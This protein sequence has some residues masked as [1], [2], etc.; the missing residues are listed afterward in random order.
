MNRLDLIR[1]QLASCD[2]IDKT[3]TISTP[4]NFKPV[5][6]EEVRQALATDSVFREFFESQMTEFQK[7]ACERWIS[8]L[9]DTINKTT[10]DMPRSMKG[11]ELVFR[12][13]K[14]YGDVHHMALGTVWRGDDGRLKVGFA[15]QES[16]PQSDRTYRG[17]VFD[18]FDTRSV[19]KGETPPVLHSM[20][21]QGLP[22]VAVRACAAPEHVQLAGWLSGKDCEHPYGFNAKEDEHGFH[23][24]TC[25]SITQMMHRAVQGEATQTNTDP[26][27]PSVFKQAMNE[28]FGDGTF[29]KYQNFSMKDQTYDMD[30]L[31]QKDRVKG[32]K[33]F[34][35][36]WGDQEKWDVQPLVDVTK[37]T[38]KF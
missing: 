32:F 22:D 35:T 19:M 18:T 33:Y 31:A 17:Q 25:F 10:A 30:Q 7:E 21:E 5:L 36:T 37:T 28:V 11:C 27:L 4:G 23:A 14:T 24:L 34:G 13:R 26:S 29:D 2:T 12:F 3:P 38:P 20:L 15:H 16:I 6:K 8:D 9:T 1:N